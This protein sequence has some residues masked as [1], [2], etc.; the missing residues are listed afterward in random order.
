VLRDGKK[1]AA[2]NILTRLEADT[3]TWESKNRT[4]DGKQL[5]DIKPIK[6]KRVKYATPAPLQERRPIPRR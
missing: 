2:T 4:E 6:M 3:F 5:P 1:L